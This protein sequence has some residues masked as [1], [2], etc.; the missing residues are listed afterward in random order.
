M[1]IVLAQNIVNDNGAA[2]YENEMFSGAAIYADGTT[3][4]N[5]AL[6]S[7]GIR[8][9]NYVP[10]FRIYDKS[11]AQIV[12]DDDL[13]NPTDYF[14][15]E[16]MLFT[17]LVYYVEKN[18]YV[19]K[20]ITQMVKGIPY[21]EVNFEDSVIVEV[22]DVSFDGSIKQTFEWDKAG[23]LHFSSVYVGGND[24]YGMT[25]IQDPDYHLLTL[26][27]IDGNY[28]T[29]ICE[30]ANISKFNHLT[31]PEM[32]C[33]EKMSNRLELHGSGINYEVL[34]LLFGSDRC[35]KLTELYMNDI[36]LEPRIVE[37][38]SECM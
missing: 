14:R 34:K 4:H 5:V 26:L 21:C 30:N 27:R 8:V 10:P 9:G 13:Y 17:G 3:V 7:A 22:H 38:L 28:F 35:K 19:C 12:V 2:L 24:R 18:T 29:N 25:M 20:N 1:K 33:V 23:R 31:K 37:P 11:Q 16:G 15:C 32:L 36:N 6:F